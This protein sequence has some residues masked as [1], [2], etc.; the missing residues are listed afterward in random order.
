MNPINSSEMMIKQMALTAY[1]KENDIVAEYTCL[2]G[3]QPLTN[4]NWIGIWEGEQILWDT[5]PIAFVKIK[6]NNAIN[7]VPLFGKRAPNMNYIIGYGTSCLL[8]G[9][10]AST[11]EEK[12]EAK[13]AEPARKKISGRKPIPK[14]NGTIG[15]T[16]QVNVDGSCEEPFLTKINAIAVGNNMLLLDYE[17]PV[18][19]IPSQNLNWVGIWPGY[20]VSFNG[21]N[22]LYREDVQSEFSSGQICI[23]GF[24]FTIDT[25]YTV[26]YAVG[27]SDCDI[28]TTVTFT[29]MGY[30]S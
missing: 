13:K 9:N 7:S 3:N 12:T 5:T 20:T 21:E 24:S 6:N 26:A 18:G 22:C 15:A 30:G 14:M 17:T 1:A 11:E 25:T 4:G 27:P 8:H 2:S 16:V 10:K 29:T 19:N 23:S 28:I